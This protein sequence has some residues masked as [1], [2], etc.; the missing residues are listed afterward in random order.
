MRSTIPDFPLTTQHILW[1]A[2]TLFGKK[3]I[4][5]RRE[6]GVRRYT[7]ADFGVR[8]ARLA[9]ALRRLGVESGDRVGTFAFNND[10]HLE[11]YFAVS[12]MGAVL[13]TLNVRLFPKHLEYIINDAED[14]VIFF[15]PPLLPVLGALAGKMPTV[16][17]FV[18]MADG[19]V[20]SGPL[21]PLAS[22]E[23][24]LAAEPTTFAWPALHESDAAAMCYTSGTTGQPKGVVYSHRS[25]FLH[26]MGEVIKGG[27]GPEED[28]VI[29]PVVPMFH[30]M[31]WGLPYSATLQGATQVLPD[32]YLDPASL[33]DLINTERVTFTAGV[34]TV[35]LALLQYLDKTGVTMPSLRAI[36][37]GGAAVPEALMRGME[38]HGLKMIHAWGMTETSPLGTVSSPKSYLRTGPEDELRLRLRQGIPAPTVEMRLVELGTDRLLP[39]DGKSVGELEVRGPWIAGAY[40]KD[41]DPER[42]TK[43][44]WLRTGDVC[45][46]D[47]EGY[48]QIVDR[49]KDLVK[50]GGEWISSVEVESAIMGHPKVLEAAVIG[51]SHPKWQE[52]PVAYVVPKPE[53]KGNVSQEEILGFLAPKMAKWWLPD[54]VRFIDEMP[55]TSVGKFDKKVL[56]AQARALETP[57]E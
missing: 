3:E 41:A 2:T 35:W 19:P 14:K 9:N 13:H 33:V 39:W 30:A 24:V 4:V 40:Y 42:F 45:N 32:R 29:L 20:P 26:A 5:T 43:D 54:E 46:I 31:G 15:D 8:V 48:V 47:P 21:E 27:I 51:V 28:D 50:S 1:R 7:Y 56:R 37:C 55:K 52:R 18:A 36:V 34:P 17:H 6:K 12:S 23:D 38:R 11:L 10:R 57:S 25:T 53:F 16:K 49:T 22:Y 44:G